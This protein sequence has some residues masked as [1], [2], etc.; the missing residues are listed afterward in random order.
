ME[1]SENLHGKSRKISC[2]H[3]RSVRILEILRNLLN[4]EN[5]Q[6]SA[7]SQKKDWGPLLRDYFKK[8][9]AL[10][11]GPKPKPPPKGKNA[12]CYGPGIGNYSPENEGKLHYCNK[13]FPYC[14]GETG[15]AF[16][17]K[18]ENEES[19]VSGGN[20]ADARALL[21]A[22]YDENAVKKGDRWVDK[23]AKKKAFEELVKDFGQIKEYK[24]IKRNF[25]KI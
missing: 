4:S 25:G 24:S 5:P 15:N 19:P 12:P 18:S 22:L 13:D 14:V 3:K 7:K 2:N 6:K 21:Q 20:E 10:K 16:C 23:I 9:K 8:R 11:P 17:K 1:I